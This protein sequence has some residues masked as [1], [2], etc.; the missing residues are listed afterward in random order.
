MMNDR[1]FAAG[2]LPRQE[3]PLGGS[4]PRGVGAF[5]EH[6]AETVAAVPMTPATATRGIYRRCL[7]RLT[8]F[9]GAIRV[10]T[11]VPTIL[12]L[13]E[14]GNSSQYSIATWL[15]WIAANVTMTVSLWEQN[16]RKPNNL[17]V[18]NLF[19]TMMCLITIGFIA[20]FRLPGKV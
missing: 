10:V 19:N 14:S 7:S 12:A 11:Y 16:D 1:F 5:S 18:I 9:F 15:L 2:P 3:A 13:C 20:Y 4:K 17:I 6:Q 8:N